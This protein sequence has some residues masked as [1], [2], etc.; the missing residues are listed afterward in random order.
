MKDE[1]VSLACRWNGIALPKSESWREERKGHR[2]KAPNVFSSR[3]IAGL[4]PF[5]PP[6]LLFLISSRTIAGLAPFRS[7]SPAHLALPNPS[8]ARLPFKRQG[9]L[10]GFVTDAGADGSDTALDALLRSAPIAV[11]RAPA[12]APA[13]APAAPTAPAASGSART[14]PAPAAAKVKAEPD[15]AKLRSLE[16]RRLQQLERARKAQAA[17]GAD[18]TAA[19]EDEE[20]DVDDVDEPAPAEDDADIDIV[21]DDRTD[22]DDEE[23]LEEAGADDE[24]GDVDAENYVP[25]AHEAAGR[26]GAGADPMDPERLARTLFVGNV[27]VAALKKVRAPLGPCLPSP[28]AN[29]R[30]RICVFTE[31]GPR[32]APAV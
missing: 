13:L 19:D 15:E 25:P 16:Q 32:T 28:R 10:F 6:S 31:Q 29:T 30:L 5:S 14:P 9:G 22:A 18:G 11:P 8:P 3:T 1:T 4:A 12:P 21:G 26:A 27:P 23:E 7:S 2:T 20:V 17:G 24:D